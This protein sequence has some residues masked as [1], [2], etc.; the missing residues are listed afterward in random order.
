MIIGISRQ[1]PQESSEIT[2]TE[3]FLKGLA[4]HGRQL[5]QESSEITETLELSPDS[6]AFAASAPPRI[7]RDY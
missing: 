2:E 4:K 3:E 6:A 7:V 1:L 5:P